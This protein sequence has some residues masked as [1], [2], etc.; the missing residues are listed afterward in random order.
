MLSKSL[1]EI[2]A[3][4]EVVLPASARL[5]D[6]D[7]DAE[8]GR[9][10]DY[11]TQSGAVQQARCVGL[12][13]GRSGSPFQQELTPDGATVQ[14]RRRYQSW[15]GDHN[16]KQ[17]RT[18]DNVIAHRDRAVTKTDFPPLKT[19]FAPERQSLEER[20]RDFRMETTDIGAIKR[21]KRHLCH[22]QHIVYSGSV[23]CSCAG[24]AYSE[25]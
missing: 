7:L 14:V 11:G 25:G 17:H 6:L 12:V 8:L 9:Q 4:I 19:P 24:S 3:G 10:A 2:A 1:F 13:N 22:L 21:A 23:R 15:S 5:L 16:E 18:P 20:Y